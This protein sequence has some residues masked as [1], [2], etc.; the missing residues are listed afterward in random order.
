MNKGFLK[1]RRGDSPFKRVLIHITLIICCIIAIYPITRIF[2]VSLRPGDRLLTTDLKIIPE[3]ASW[4]NYKEV[5]LDSNFLLWLWNS[6][7]ITITTSILGVLLATSA[8]YAF[9]RFRFPG[10]KAGLLFI[11]AT[12]MIP[13]SMLLLPLYIML[14]RLKMINSYLGLIIA[15]SVTALP[16]TIWILKG[17][18]DT[19]PPELEEAARVD[20]ATHLGAFYKI[21]IPL[22]TPALAIA[23]LFNFTAAWN[24]YLVARVIIQKSTLYT[25]PLGLFEFQGQ[26]STQ[27]GLYNAAS[28]MISIPVLILFLY[29]SKWLISGLTLGAVKG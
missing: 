6:I 11:L 16:F 21:I 29:S 4:D 5:L 7:L 26:F 3:D 12:Q 2:S 18:F 13:A 27:W 20:G 1:A 8:G 24:E 19:I 25:W 15:Y 17:Y 22:S 23:A 9:S 14:V 28:I 10:H